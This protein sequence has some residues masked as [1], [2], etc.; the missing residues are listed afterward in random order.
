VE[1]IRKS[2]AAIVLDDNS[3]VNDVNPA[4][5]SEGLK[6][7]FCLI[8]RVSP[9]PVFNELTPYYHIPSPSPMDASLLGKYL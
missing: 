4:V 8:A 9:Y 6:E 5:D 1:V 7:E 2:P 3:D